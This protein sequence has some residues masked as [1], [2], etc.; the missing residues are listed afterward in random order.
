MEQLG[1]NL[2][3]RWFVELSLDVAVWDVTVFTKNREREFAKPTDAMIDAAYEAVRFDKDWVITLQRALSKA[4]KTMVCVPKRRHKQLEA[5]NQTPRDITLAGFFARGCLILP[6][7]NLPQGTDHA[8]GR[9]VLV[10]IGQKNAHRHVDHVEGSFDLFELLQRAEVGR[11]RPTWI[12]LRPCGPGNL[13]DI[14]IAV[15]IDR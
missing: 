4:V 8:G 3:F 10:N 11:V 9:P 7:R 1:Y 12:D 15:R 14:N 2:L 6:G 5:F 13:A